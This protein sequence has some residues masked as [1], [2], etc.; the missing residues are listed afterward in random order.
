VSRVKL[1]ILGR[2]SFSEEDGLRYSI[3][4][5][6]EVNLSSSI[7]KYETESSRRGSPLADPSQLTVGDLVVHA[8]HGVG[9]YEGVQRFDG[10][11]KQQCPFLVLAYA[12]QK[13]YVPLEMMHLIQKCT[14]Q[15]HRLDFLS[16]DMDQPRTCCLEAL[17]N[18]YEWPSLG[19]FPELQVWNA[20]ASRE[21]RKACFAYKNALHADPTYRKASIELLE[22]QRREPQALLAH[23]WAYRDKVLGVESTELEAL[24]DRETE[25]LMV[26]RY[27]LRLNRSHEKLQREV[28]ALENPM[29]VEDARREPIPESVRLFVWQRDRGQCVRCGSRERLEFDHIIPIIAGGSNTERNI[30]LLCEPCNRSK[31][32][33]I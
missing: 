28:E 9:R 8:D 5:P 7:L 22:C 13:L 10:N 18:A 4:L 25:V 1:K 19:T 12:D 30:Q 11:C 32:A 2:L 17:P 14:D 26:R 24:R 16:V 27:V 20:T 3:T 31:G 21:W 6:Q 33:T 23:W 29:Q 15:V